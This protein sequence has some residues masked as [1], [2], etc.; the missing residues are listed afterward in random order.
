MGDLITGAG[1]A[2]LFTVTI[3]ALLYGVVAV[4]RRI[5]VLDERR[6]AAGAAASQD[7]WETATIAGIDGTIQVILRRRPAPGRIFAGLDQVT[8]ASIRAD[9]PA[10]VQDLIAAQ[11]EAEERLAVLRASEPAERRRP[12]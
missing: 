11:A 7:R 10:W 1:A 6:K 12:R 4:R 9:S 5:A 8:V 2:V 3:L